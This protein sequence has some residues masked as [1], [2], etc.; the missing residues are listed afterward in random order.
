MELRGP[1][2]SEFAEY[3]RQ[4][5]SRIGISLARR[6]CR[7]ESEAVVPAGMTQQHQI[8]EGNGTKSDLVSDQR[9]GLDRSGRS[10]LPP[11]TGPRGI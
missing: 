10:D 5:T 2:K 8:E 11:V 6:R 7:N 4:M 3:F 1:L 9:S